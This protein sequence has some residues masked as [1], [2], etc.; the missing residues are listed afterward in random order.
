MKVVIVD[1][2][3][4]LGFLLRM[5]YHIPKVKEDGV[6]GN[7]TAEAVS[8]FQGIFGLPKTGVVDFKTWY[9]ISRVYVAVTKIASLNPNI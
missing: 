9:E 8:T 7:S 4:I 5:Y 1:H 3:K 2:P 6:Y